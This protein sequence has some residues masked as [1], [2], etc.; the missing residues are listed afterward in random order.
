MGKE[1]VRLTA[2]EIP[3]KRKSMQ[4]ISIR[5]HGYDRRPRLRR[6]AYYEEV[7]VDYRAK[8]PLLWALKKRI[9]L[10]PD[11][12]QCRE[13]RKALPGCLRWARFVE[14]WKPGDFI[15]TSRQKVRSRVQRLLLEGHEKNFPDASVP[16]LYRSKDSR[17]Q[18]IMVPDQQELILNNVVDVP[19]KYVRE[20]LG[21][22]WQVGSWLSHH[23][24]LEPRSHRRRSPEG[25]DHRWL[26]PVVKSRLLGCL[27]GRV[28]AP[29]R[30]GS[31][32]PRGGLWGC[33]HAHRAAA[34][35]SL[36]E[37]TG[38]LQATGPGQEVEV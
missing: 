15:F 27:K 9:S 38:G 11:K 36:P 7:E 17:R 5:R 35:Q 4:G 22:K 37:E 6:A 30:E 14:A 33:T 20:V 29:A 34:P 10:R 23:S 18:N 21:G 28:Y 19:L 32:S 13:V 3:F 25:L 2:I 26:P 31:L 1:F 24:P 8:D 16:L 12:I